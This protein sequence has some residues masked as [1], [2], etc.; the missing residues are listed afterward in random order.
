MAGIDTL[1]IMGVTTVEELARRA[2][3][4]DALALNQL[5]AEIRPSVLRRC[6]R[7]LPCYQ[8]AEEA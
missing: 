5:L 4:G 6:A 8:D 3:D 2:A 1:H 7:F